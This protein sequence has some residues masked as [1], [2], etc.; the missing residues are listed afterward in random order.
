M[1]KRNVKFVVDEFMCTNCGV[2]EGVCP[3]DCIEMKIDVYGSYTPII[4]QETC[5]DCT[6]CVKAC[7]GHDFD[8]FEYQNQVFGKISKDN[9][10]G[11]YISSFA[12]YTND[13]EILL[14]SQS[15]GVVSTFV[16]YALEKGLI[17]GA[18]LT[19][20]SKDNP[21]EPEIFI[22]KKREDVLSAVGSK[23][24]PVPNAKIIQE[25]LKIDGKYIFVGVS[26]QIQGMRKAERIYPKLKERV[27]L[28]IGLHCLGVFTY[29]YH[30]QILS[31]L[32]LQKND[33]SKFTFRDKK[34]LGWPCHMEIID[35]SGNINNIHANKSRLYPRNF[36]TNWRCNLCFDKGAEFSDISTGDCRISEI[37]EYYKNKNYDLKNGLSEFVV[38]TQRGQE[39]MKYVLEDN[40]MT[41][42]KTDSEKVAKSI[43]ISGK[44]LGMKYFNKIAKLFGKSVPN[45]NVDF[46]NKSDDFSRKKMIVVMS[47]YI[48]AFRYFVTYSMSRNKSFRNF[49][50]L[51]PH[52]FFRILDWPM[53]KTA[54]WE[55][56][57]SEINI[58]RKSFDDK[59]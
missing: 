38:R 7:P 16:I 45:F 56:Y 40:L 3:H 15:G 30:D 48:F 8:Y 46:Y 44:K 2:C 59:D 42:I 6:L 43:G 1:N 26:C 50:K 55:R 24:N 5:T 28:Y 33:V 13:K 27:Y 49:L 9:I 41:L 12:G 32:N 57:L 21:L 36:F 35:K 58:E 37:H 4:N 25:L 14:K 22:A 19:R 34:W 23:Y 53:K 17:N 20:W 18:V 39:F 47:S 29:H 52:K 10:L 11:N 51:I 31:K 54:E